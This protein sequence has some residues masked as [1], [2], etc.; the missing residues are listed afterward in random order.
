MT[1]LMLSVAVTPT[2]SHERISSAEM[3]SN[4]LY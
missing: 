2:D 3:D 1:V 4:H